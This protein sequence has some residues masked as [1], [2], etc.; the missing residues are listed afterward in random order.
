MSARYAYPRARISRVTPAHGAWPRGCEGSAAASLGRGQLLRTPTMN[1]K[2][3]P[4]P[5]SSFVFET[6]F[7]GC[8]EGVVMRPHMG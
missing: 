7:E 3:A 6:G 5:S 8:A 2:S 4:A 1:R